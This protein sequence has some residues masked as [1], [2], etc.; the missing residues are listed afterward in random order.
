MKYRRRSHLAAAAVFLS[1]LSGPATRFIVETPVLR[2]WCDGLERWAIARP[3]AR[4]SRCAEN[5][6]LEA[7]AAFAD[8]VLTVAN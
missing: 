8:A 6:G 5:G 3:Q 2:T 7:P 4:G 1:R